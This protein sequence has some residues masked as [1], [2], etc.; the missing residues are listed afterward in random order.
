M[1]NASRIEAL[2]ANAAIIYSWL[3]VWILPA[4]SKIESSNMACLPETNSAAPAESLEA[5]FRHERL[6]ARRAISTRGA[7]LLALRPGD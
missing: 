1:T 3:R 2:K 4:D 6:A 7:G 5:M